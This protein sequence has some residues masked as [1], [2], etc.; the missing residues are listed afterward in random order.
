MS[1]LYEQWQPSVGDRVRV[2][3]RD[4]TGAAEAYGPTGT[5]VSVHPA[6]PEALCEVEYD[7]G[8]GRQSH[9]ILE[10]EPIE[11]PAVRLAHGAPVAGRSSASGGPA[12]QPTVG[13]RVAIAGAER[14]GTVTAVE[15]RPDGTVCE[16]A[17]DHEPGEPDLPQRR[18]YP[19]GELSPVGE[20]SAAALGD[21]RP[22]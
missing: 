15:D 14:A 18:W 4:E 20:P 8:S 5:I 11:E 21:Q 1:S 10:L 16:V 12:W 6:T 17:F 13:D 9:A 19:I 3:M 2:V 22:A 7:G